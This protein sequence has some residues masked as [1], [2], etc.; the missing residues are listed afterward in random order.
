MTTVVRILKS[1][2]FNPHFFEYP[3]GY[4]YVQVGTARS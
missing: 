2:S 1:G 4:I 3:T